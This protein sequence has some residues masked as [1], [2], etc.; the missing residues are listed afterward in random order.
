MSHTFFG[1]ASVVGAYPAVYQ[2]KASANAICQIV[3]NELS[4][5]VICW[6][7][8][9]QTSSDDTRDEECDDVKAS[10]VVV[11]SKIGSNQDR[12]D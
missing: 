9:H 8:C 11:A 6:Q 7:E 5:F 12:N 2:G 10:L 1:V 4:G 3:P